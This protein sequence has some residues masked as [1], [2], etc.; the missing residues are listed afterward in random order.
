MLLHPFATLGLIVSNQQKVTTL[1]VLFAPFLFLGLFSRYALLVIPLL[2]ERLLSDDPT[3]WGFNYQHYSAVV[4]VVVA[5]ASADGFARIMVW[6]KAGARDHLRTGLLWTILVLNL[7]LLPVKHYSKLSALFK[8]SY[9]ELTENDRIGAE[10]MRLVP[11]NVSVMAQ[12]PIVP[13]LSH[14]KD[15]YL[16]SDID[17]GRHPNED[18]LVACDRLNVWPFDD[19][20]PIERYLKAKEAAGY[21]KVYEKDGWIVLKKAGTN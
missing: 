14:R 10:V 21:S 4:A 16:M 17:F 18:Y 3:F 12:S 19:L 20:G 1:I 15:I 9:Y 2:C 7:S 8:P 6:R 11:N 13:H 5:F